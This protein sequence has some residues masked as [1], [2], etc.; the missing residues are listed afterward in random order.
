MNLFFYRDSYFLS[1]FTSSIVIE[2]IYQRMKEFFEN[3]LKKPS[4]VKFFYMF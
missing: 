2:M 1:I 3:F 4:L